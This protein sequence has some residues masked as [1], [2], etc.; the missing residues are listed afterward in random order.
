MSSA[1]SLVWGNGTL[2]NWP[3]ADSDI[4]YSLLGGIS[5]AASMGTPSSAPSLITVMLSS[6]ILFSIGG[7]GDCLRC[8]AVG[9]WPDLLAIPILGYGP[10]T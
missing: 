2:Y 7:G 3:L 9:E 4:E 8:P 1:I 10:S 5:G 6:C